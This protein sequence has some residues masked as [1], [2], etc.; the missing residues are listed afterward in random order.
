MFKFGNSERKQQK[1]HDAFIKQR[2]AELLKG[3]GS[4]RR[5]KFTGAGFIAANQVP[6]DETVVGVFAGNR[7]GA[8]SLLVAT[9]KGLYVC[10]AGLRAAGVES[11][12]YSDSVD[13]SAG[14]DRKGSF[15]QVR[16]GNYVVKIGESL[17]RN[18]MEFAAA[19]Q[20]AMRA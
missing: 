18:G 2:S 1:E 20:A 15:V 9:E 3:V 7:D 12:K 11:F 19:A 8:A 6:R 5:P 10:T 17:S 14:A 13:V 16:D 4:M